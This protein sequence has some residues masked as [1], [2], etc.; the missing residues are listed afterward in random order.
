VTTT[1]I[2]AVLVPIGRPPRV[3]D[4]EPATLWSELG[5]I[6][7][8]FA[9]FALTPFGRRFAAVWC[10]NV[11]VGAPNRIV[12]APMFRYQEVVAEICGPILM[13]A[14]KYNDEALALRATEATT[15]IVAASRWPDLSVQPV[16]IRNSLAAGFGRASIIP[17]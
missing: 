11:A 14:A 16:S 3:V 6:P 5:G 4:A 7:E 13:T 2:R 10:C 12:F 8:H 1:A 9:S 15:C 17:S